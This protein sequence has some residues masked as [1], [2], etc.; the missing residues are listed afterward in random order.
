MSEVAAIKSLASALAAGLRGFLVRI[1]K[2]EILG[3]DSMT[4]LASAGSRSEK[5]FIKT[6]HSKNSNSSGNDNFDKFRFMS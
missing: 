5:R 2:E 6:R 4:F 3:K 1:S